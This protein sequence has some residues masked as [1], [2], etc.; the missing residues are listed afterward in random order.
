MWVL[1]L[2]GWLYVALFAVMLRTLFL[3]LRTA[4]RKL[5]AAEMRVLELERL[6]DKLS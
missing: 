4:N 2:Y 6:L 5:Q 1:A 3:E